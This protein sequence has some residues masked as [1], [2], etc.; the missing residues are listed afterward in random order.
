M[1]KINFVPWF[2]LAWE[3]RLHICQQ[4]QGPI[5]RFD[6][7]VNKREEKSPLSS[8]GIAK[9]GRK[10]CTAVMTS[11]D[12]EV[13]FNGSD[14]VDRNYE[15]TSDSLPSDEDLQ[16]HKTKKRNKRSRPEAWKKN[17]QKKKRC[18]GEE[19]VGRGDKNVPPKSLKLPC[20]CR[21]KC[22]DRIPE[23]LCHSI[24]RKFWD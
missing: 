15:L 23:D 20:Y 7:L 14:I 12:N 17:T 1:D 19:Y 2:R 13:D 11:S 3:R 8:T 18:A 22:Q 4:F 9:P 6:I 10:E 16:V 5:K 21:R 24:N